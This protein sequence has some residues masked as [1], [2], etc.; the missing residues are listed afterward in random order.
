MYLGYNDQKDTEIKTLESLKFEGGWQ[1]LWIVNFLQDIVLC[2][3]FRTMVNELNKC[4]FMVKAD[5]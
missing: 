2:I 4:K 3:Y 1:F 5:R